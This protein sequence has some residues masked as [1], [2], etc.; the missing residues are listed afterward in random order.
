MLQKLNTKQG[1]N[2][3]NEGEKE[4]EIQEKKKKQSGTSKSFLISNYM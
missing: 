3:E 1:R 2:E 4:Q